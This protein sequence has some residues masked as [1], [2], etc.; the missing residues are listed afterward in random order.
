MKSIAEP[1]TKAEV[2]NLFAR[3]TFSAINLIN[4]N[5]VRQMLSSVG[6]DYD[7][8]KA[9]AKSMTDAEILQLIGV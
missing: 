6:L 7:A 3:E 8:E 2:Y 1:V 9:K 5:V 4:E